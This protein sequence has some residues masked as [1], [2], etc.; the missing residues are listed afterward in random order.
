MLPERK[1]RMEDTQSR[2][3]KEYS[4][5]RARA[6]LHSQLNGQI[7]DMFTRRVEDIGVRSYFVSTLSHYIKRLAIEEGQPLKA[8]PNI[9]FDTQLPLIAEGI[10][11]IQYLE[12][13]ILDKKDGTSG[14]KTTEKR[15][16]DQ[17]LIASHYLKDFLYD[18]IDQDLLPDD[19]EARQKITRSVRRIFQYVDI[20][21]LMQ[22]EWGTFD[23]FRHG[24]KS[25]ISL[26]S[27]ID[28]FI[29][30]SIIRHLWDIIIGDENEKMNLNKTHLYFTR[31]YLRR[32]YLT[33][34]A[35]FV[36]L[37]EL[38]MDLLGF[39]GSKRNNII[40][41][42]ASIGIIGQLVNDICDFAPHSTVAK[43][44]EDVFSDI[45][46]NIITLPL[47]LYLDKNPGI[48]IEYLN[49]LSK[50]A[51]SA[52]KLS[53]NSRQAFY[54]SDLLCEMAAAL[55]YTL[56][57]IEE[58]RN[59][60]LQFYNLEIQEGVLLEDLNSISNSRQNR[61]F[62]E[63]FSHVGYPEHEKNNYKKEPA[64]VL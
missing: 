2:I 5:L 63:M 23:L 28:A 15:R 38:E 29:D 20:G 21:Q 42:A 62:R 52:Y 33:S 10:I 16:R 14:C 19:P 39:K 18:Y 49:K 30:N 26:S 12:N 46:N 54:K 43:N 51:E 35:L 60:C 61:T 50:E 64:F 1:K 3:S 58:V 6:D 32:V 11:T 44:A 40:K 17:K 22:D 37:A 34:G 8:R 13:Q 36:L 9:L 53:P 4:R 31:N 45:Q 7:F 56:Q 25:D 47:S 57:I 27:E 55:R 41:A 59:S 24:H 48:D